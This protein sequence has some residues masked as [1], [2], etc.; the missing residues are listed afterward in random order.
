MGSDEDWEDGEVEEGEEVEENVPAP[1]QPVASSNAEGT[2]KDAA[3]SSEGN[4]E[5]AH[6]KPRLP[7]AGPA[8]ANGISPPLPPPLPPQPY[9]TFS[10]QSHPSYSQQPRQQPYGARKRDHDGSAHAGSNNQQH[11]SYQGHG[12]GAGSTSDT[13]DERDLEQWIVKY[14]RQAVQSKVLLN[15]GKWMEMARLRHRVFVDELQTLLLRTVDS[16][17]AAVSP[18]LLDPIFPGQHNPTKLCLVLL[19]NLHPCVL[20]RYRKD[21]SFFD[22]CSSMPCSLAKSERAKKIETPVAE[23][24][25]KFP[26]PPVSTKNLSI[27]ELFYA[28][29]LTFLLVHSAG[30]SD[31]LVLQPSGY[32]FRRTQPQGGTWELDGD[33]LHLKWRQKRK[34]AAKDETGD[35]GDDVDDIVS[36]DVL[37]SEDSTMHYFSTDPTTDATYAHEAA[38]HL[39]TRR[40]RETKP[41]TMR[42]SLI[43]AAVM[44]VPCSPG[45]SM[46]AKKTA[47][48]N[49]ASASVKNNDD[50]DVDLSD[51]SA[52]DYYVLSLDELR[53]HG[54][55]VTVDE[56]Q[57]KLMKATDGC[58][59][60]KYVLTQPRPENAEEP[61]PHNKVYALDCE[62]CETDIGYELT[63]VTVV[64]AH[65]EVLYDHLVKPRSTI[66]NYHTEFSGITEEMM[67]SVTHTLDDVQ[68]DLLE[69]IYD[70]CIVVGHS[71]NSDLEAL[72]IVHLKVVDT[73][74]LY[75]HQRGFPFKTSLKFLSKTY[76][77]KSIQTRQMEG[78]DS[79]EDAIAAMELYLMKLRHGASFGIPDTQM[80]SAAFESM[81]EKMAS[82]EKKIS[83]YG[84]RVHSSSSPDTVD[85][86]V[87]PVNQKPWQLFSSGHMQ[88]KLENPLEH[89]KQQFRKDKGE[90]AINGAT[91]H[92]HHAISDVADVHDFDA[93]KEKMMQSLRTDDLCW[94]DIEK[95]T[96][97]DSIDQFISSHHKWMDSEFQYCKQLNTFLEE[98]VTDV[99]PPE[100]L[101]VVMPQADLSVLNHL[102]GL[103][104]RSRWKDAAA[105]AQ[106]WTNDMQAA[107]SD[108]LGGV[109]DSCIFLR[110][111]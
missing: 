1:P 100:T 34:G 4:D 40:S 26:R 75:P 24:L 62:M 97:Q 8:P 92:H 47:D 48:G 90:K 18:F 72:R 95:H 79:A 83:L 16:R 35:N 66:I 84:L 7:D 25:Y 11:K 98:I 30:W 44:D 70:D 68:K 74:V 41:R 27:D 3:E 45:G 87:T 81:V 46:I 73:A 20:Q 56:A 61:K 102:K 85:D 63:R 107:L 89:A 94:V 38:D 64:N 32:F 91:K 36:L 12:A 42:M 22:A 5:P 60:D 65:L 33:L 67:Q 88:R 105:K 103:R 53:Q 37:V 10:Q 55:S 19:G 110:Q 28:H 29:E 43:K 49:N 111:K 52:L 101:L 6:K 50:V 109:I 39:R 14:P 57:E 21:L 59:K 54:F 108:A 71:L 93:L 76:L 80:T 86:D 99:L 69:M 82:L 17:D 96:T 78:H 106:F 13:A 9:A 23:L 51:S 31:E 2:S 15:F 58:S 104:T 77:S